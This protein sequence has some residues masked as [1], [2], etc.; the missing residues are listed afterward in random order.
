MKFGGD[1]RRLT[2]FYSD[3]YANDQLGVYKY[4]GQVTSAVQPGASNPY[5]GNPYAAFLLGV[6]DQTQL[7]TVLEPDSSAYANHYAFFAQDDW[8]VTSRLTVN[9]GLR[10]EYHPMFLDHLVNVTNFL[11]DYTSIVN[12]AVVR[13][14]V[15][16][17]NQAAFKILNQGFADSIAPTPILTAAQAGL[18]LGM[19]F[20]QKTD[21]APRVGLSGR[22]FVYRN[23][24]ISWG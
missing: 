3:V 19:R 13:G 15:V 18:P 20:S 1:Y 5:I 16:I 4:T 10:W 23:S 6:P 17:P 2:G 9:F 8:K 11:P 22:P 7:A 24:V 14:A 12:G 21:F